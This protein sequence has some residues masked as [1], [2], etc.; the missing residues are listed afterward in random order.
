MS[1]TCTY[2]VLPFRLLVGCLARAV[3]KTAFDRKT[4][5]KSSDVVHTAFL[6]NEQI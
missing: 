3:R 2:Y 1:W 6:N 4:N 5:L